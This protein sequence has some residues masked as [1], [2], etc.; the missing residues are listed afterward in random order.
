[1]WTFSLQPPPAKPSASGLLNRQVPVL[2]DVGRP[3]SPG[4]KPAASSQAEPLNL[5]GLFTALDKFCNH[6]LSLPA[7]AN[8]PEIKQ[9]LDFIT[10]SKEK[11]TLALAEQFARAQV[12]RERLADLAQTM[13]QKQEAHR[14]QMEELTR[15]SPPLDGNDLGRELLK[16]LG[17]PD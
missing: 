8:R 3:E 9:Q 7:A 1:M 13:K 5:D 14:R 11:L 12:H 17:L 6:I 2:P 15:P 16:N 4:A 10:A